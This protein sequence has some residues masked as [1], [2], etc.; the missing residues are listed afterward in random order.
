MLSRDQRN[1]VLTKNPDNYW[2]SFAV[3]N[4]TVTRLLDKYI[5]L[6]RAMGEEMVING[7]KLRLSTIGKAESQDGV[8]FSERS[9]FINPDKDFE[10]FG[11]E[12]P[13]VTLIDGKYIITYTAIANWPPTAKGIRIAAAISSDLK[14]IERKELVT[15]FNAKAM[16]I[17]PEK[18]NGKY[19]ALL[20]VNT[21]TP[22][23]HIALAQFDNLEDIFDQKY[24][25]NWYSN[26]D[27][28]I[29][30]L[31]RINSDQVEIGAQPVLTKYGWLLVY[32]YIKHYLSQDVE[33][34]FRIEAVFLDKEDP[35]KIIG[36]V[37]KPLLIPETEYEIKGQINN[38]VFPEGAIV[39]DNILNVYYGGA[40]SVCAVGS[41]S[42]ESLFKS[43]EIN[44]PHT[45]K[46]QKFK[47]NPI[48]LPKPENKWESRA[49]FN[50][51][52]FEYDGK[53]YILYRTTSDDYVSN[54]GLAISYD[55]YH[56]DERLEYPIYPLR[57]SFELPHKSGSWSGAEDP[58]VTLIDT[59]LHLLY[60]A[61]DGLLP[62]LAYSH[63]DLQ[64]FLLRK[65]DKWSM[66]KIISP[67]GLADKDGVL[68]HEKVDNKF[69]FL[70]RIEPD[71]IIATRDSLDFKEGEFLENNGKISPQSGT[72]DAVKIGVN[73]PPVRTKEGFLVFYHGISAI[74]RHYRL[75]AL[76]LDL[77]DVRIVLARAPYPI[78]EPAHYYER[79]GVVSNVVFPCGQILK[80]NKI[81]FYYGGADKVVC[82]AEIEVDMLIDYLLKSQKKRYLIP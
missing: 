21:D 79:N 37:D 30:H 8:N 78:L 71:I 9:L 50:P 13:R 76:L 20:T 4:G 41:V 10:I 1:P 42:L 51:A 53:V 25:K 49:V 5:M 34:I 43:T 40:D 6:Y 69:V 72:W 39:K 57:M 63:I 59:K 77:N 62:R 73:G 75:G 3:F 56:I 24:W 22:P 81:V 16:V 82:G 46:C 58:R 65:F 44:T 55:G 45:I 70:H 66:P 35:K 27:R 28:H 54:I 36:R 7:K 23:S 17:F 18:I 68:F 74:D 26:L 19:S 38:V 31:R 11:A 33:K 48:L 12:D 64:D 32:S 80:N 15:P 47:Y 52:A 61:Y 14:S 29:V 60:T 2:E 67:P